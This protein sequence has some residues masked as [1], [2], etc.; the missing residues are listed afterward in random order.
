M[1]AIATTVPCTAPQLCA[2]GRTSPPLR[3][4]AATTHRVGSQFH[5]SASRVWAVSTLH[6]VGCFPAPTCGVFKQNRSEK[7]HTAT[8]ARVRRAASACL[9]V[10]LDLRSNSKEET[11][12]VKRVF[13]R[14]HDRSPAGPPL[15]AGRTHHSYENRAELSGFLWM[16]DVVLPG[17]THRSRAPR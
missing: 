5:V 9:H 14:H 10:Q 13:A 3:H 6:L 2:K 7:V 12:P 17:R 8:S 15:H 11:A 16:L 1:P 4:F